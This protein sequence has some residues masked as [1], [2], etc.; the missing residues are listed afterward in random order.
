VKKSFSRTAKSE[1]LP[2]S[3]VPTVSSAIMYSEAQLPAQLNH[4]N[5]ADIHS[6]EHSD[7][8]HLVVLGR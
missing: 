8:I 3:S 7:D 5:I 4:L 6:C 1:N 2:G